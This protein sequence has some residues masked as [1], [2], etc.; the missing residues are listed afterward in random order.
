MDKALVGSKAVEGL[1]LG[2]AQKATE[3]AG[4]LRKEI[5]AERT[6]SAALLAEVKLLKEQL[7]EVKALG[8]ATAKTYTT[9]LTGFGGITPPLPSEVSPSS[10]FCG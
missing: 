4:N 10:L 2:R 7:D 3:I 8:L 9:V 6:S 1:A 5:D